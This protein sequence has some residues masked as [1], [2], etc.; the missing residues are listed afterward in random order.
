[1]KYALSLI[2]SCFIFSSAFSAKQLGLDISYA[3]YM[4][5]ENEAY[6]ELYFA[7]DGNSLALQQ[8]KNNSFYGGIE[9]TVRFMQDS[10][11]RAADKFRILSPEILDT[12]GTIGVFIQQE[13]FPLANGKYTLLMDLFD[14]NNPEQKHSLK[15]NIEVFLGVDELSVSDLTFLDH[16]TEAKENSPYAKSGFDLIPLVSSGV[17]YFPESIEKISYY[18]EIYNLS[19]QIGDGEAYILKQYIENA[20]NGK[21]SDQHASLSRKKAGL[22]Q[23]VLSGFSIKE[24]PTGNYNLVVEALDRDQKTIIQKKEPFFR[25]NNAYKPIAEDIMLDD[26]SGT[27]VA[28][29]SNFDTLYQY[30]KYLYPISEEVEQNYQKNLLE[31]RDMTKMK[32]YFYAFWE[33]KNKE[34]PLGQWTEYYKNVRI[35]N[36]LYNT[37]IQR[38][39]MS[40]RGRVFLVYGSP[41]LVEDRKFEPSLPPYQIWQYNQIDS[42]YALQQNNR[43]FIF[44]EFESSTNDYELIHSTAYGELSNRRWQYD[45]AQGVYGPG[46][47]IDDNNVINGDGFGSRLNNNVILQSGGNR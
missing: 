19:K 21:I 16:Y 11:I 47:N 33:S 5:A 13:R 3:Q 40:Q 4:T 14:I 24:L 28:A 36:K 27:F 6:V 26:L 30:I 25:K 43:I 44:A 18:T 39:Y 10:I 32:S 41:S 29:Y 22:V 17:N 46:D 35:A 38:G 7:L 20:D 23:P 15:Q 1:M 37:R 8:K 2:L 12:S 45:L 42:P 9:V 34:N 31:S